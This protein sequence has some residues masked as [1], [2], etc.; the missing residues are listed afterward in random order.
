MVLAGASTLEERFAHPN[1]A[2]F[3]QRLAA[4]VYLEALDS[5]ETASYVRAQI[6]AAGGSEKLFTDEALRSVYRATDGI[7]RL[8][9]QVCD[10]ALILSSLGGVQQI[11]SEAIDEAWSDLQQLPS[12]WNTTQK[13][14]GASNVVEFGGL[15]DAPPAIPFRSAAPAHLSLA[16]ADDPLDVIEEH[17]AQI[18]E[19]R[20]AGSIGSEIEL[21]FPEFG[22]P[23][24]EEFAEEEI[25]LER[26]RSDVEMFAK[27]PRVTSLQGQQ[28]AALLESGAEAFGGA[29]SRLC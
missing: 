14:G 4:R 24:A 29:V 28:L 21:D 8:I 22:D 19:F 6:A 11:T 20:P 23:F 5:V 15:D 10:H 2:S 3:S 7:G 12:P 17:L 16:E 26:Y 18:D 9:N 13:P 25:I 27:L 1:L